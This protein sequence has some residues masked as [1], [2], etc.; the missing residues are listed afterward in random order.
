MTR[1]ELIRKLLL[2]SHISVPERQMFKDQPIKFDEAKEII[3]E[4]LKKH[5]FFPPIT[6]SWDNNKFY[7]DGL[8]IEN[9]ETK[10]VLHEQL[11][12]A[13]MNL[14]FNKEDVFESIDEVIEKY[15]KPRHLDID[16]VK[17][18]E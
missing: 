16:G 14:L 18:E 13:T 8:V 11:S 10:Y 7:N 4:E 6:D 3:K 17:I 1:K 15:I 12:G 5:K 2:T 9:R